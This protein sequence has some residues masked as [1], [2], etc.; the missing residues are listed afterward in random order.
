MSLLRRLKNARKICLN[1]PA[2]MASDDDDG[3]G[4]DGRGWNIP[5]L[6]KLAEQTAPEDIPSDF[7]AGGTL[8]GGTACPKGRD[9]AAAVMDGSHLASRSP[10]VELLRKIVEAEDAIHT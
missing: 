7:A 10:V 2:L 4:W 9:E 8:N 1:K 3:D 5:L 6:A